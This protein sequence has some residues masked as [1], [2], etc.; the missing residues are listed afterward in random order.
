[1]QRTMHK[2][3]HLLEG[4]IASIVISECSISSRVTFKRQDKLIISFLRGEYCS[5]YN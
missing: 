5:V 4:L 3:H 1:M 2:Q